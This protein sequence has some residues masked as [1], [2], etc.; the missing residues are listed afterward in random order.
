MPQSAA[1]Y[2]SQRFICHCNPSCIYVTRNTPYTTGNL[3]KSKLSAMEAIIWIE[4][5]VNYFEDS[6]FSRC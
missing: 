3:I 6:M 2:C 5:I 4:F 1:I